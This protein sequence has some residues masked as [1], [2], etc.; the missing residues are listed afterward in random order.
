[1]MADMPKRTAADN[2]TR[3]AKETPK[4]P[5]SSAPAASGGPIAPPPAANPDAAGEFARLMER[6]QRVLSDRWRRQAAGE[7]FQVADPGV[8][9]KAFGRAGAAL[10]ADP[11]LLV[12]TQAKLWRDYAELW[13]A[14]GRRLNGETV[15]PLVEPLPGDRRFSDKAWSEEPYYDFVKQAYLLTARALQSSLPKAKGLDRHTARMVDFYTRQFVDAMAPTNFV[16]T[17]PQVMR[18]TV[19]SGGENLLKGLRSLVADLERGHGQPAIRMTDMNAFRVG[20]NVATTPGKVVFQNDLMQLIQYAPSTTEV[21]RRPL[22]LMPPWINKF[23]I[24]DLRPANSFI[25]WAVAQGH[26]LF[27]VSWV[28]PDARLAHKDFDD[29]MA[30]GPLAALDAIQRATGEREVNVIGY[31]ISGTLLAGTL[32]YMASTGDDRFSSATFFTAMTDFAEA[33]ELAVFIDEEQLG[34]LKRHVDETGYLEAAHMASVF[35]MMRD[36]DLIWSFVVNNYLLGKEPFAFDLLY[37]NSDSTRMPAAMHRF[38]LRNMYLENKLVRP[39]GISLKGVPIDLRDVRLPVYQLSTRDDHI[40]PW[41]STY[42]ASQLYRGPYKFVLAGSGHIAGVVN[43]P[44]ANKYG[45]WTASELPPSA[46]DWLAGATQHPGSWWTDWAAWIDGHGGGKVSARV[47]GAGG[48]APIEDAPGAY[49]K[50]K[51]DD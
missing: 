36:N 41:K 33:G 20:E 17:N 11:E 37:W 15:A 26:T 24:L 12:A 9:G 39:G 50:V 31:C 1:M 19:E 27:V 7:T 10:L 22:L 25:R 48:L 32:A 14:A 16:A 45:Y 47:P 49:V 46:D 30:E 35:N 23:Y 18:A 51:A 2:G 13:A 21:Y 3:Q 4:A 5:D 28:N 8:V 29:Y 43:P 44:A 38:Y 6:A 34:L 42:A 40:A